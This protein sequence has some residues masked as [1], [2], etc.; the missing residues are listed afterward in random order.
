MEIYF[1]DPY[2][3]THSG[4]L[5]CLCTSYAIRSLTLPLCSNLIIINT[6]GYSVSSC[7]LPLFVQ[8]KEGA[9]ISRRHN[10][11]PM[12]CRNYY[13]VSGARKSDRNMIKL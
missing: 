5:R 1:L 2:I 9:T 11:Q 7:T 8:L 12:R 4:V 6:E 13:F 10:Q 3:P